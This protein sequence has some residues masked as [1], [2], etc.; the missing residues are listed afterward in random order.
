VFILYR[1]KDEREPER[2]DDREDYFGALNVGGG[3]KGAFSATVR[4]LLAAR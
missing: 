3:E 1:I 2:T 4:E